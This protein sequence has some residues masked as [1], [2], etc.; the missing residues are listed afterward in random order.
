MHLSYNIINNNNSQ[1]GGS[2]IQKYIGTYRVF[3]QIDK[4]TSK[5]SENELDLFL[6]GKY[7]TEI[8]RHNSKKLAIYFPT[9][10]SL[11]NI[12]SQLKDSKIKLTKYLEGDLEA[13]YLF[14]EEDIHNL[15][16]ILKFQTKGKGIKPSSVRT[17]RRLVKS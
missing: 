10:S 2:L 1:K 4:T 5:V 12:S 16:E 3:P 15:H 14:N 6:K 13:V 8:Y 9:K 7:N 17:Q 11:N